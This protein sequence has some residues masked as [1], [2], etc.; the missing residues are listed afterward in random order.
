MDNALLLSRT[1]G[2]RR[3]ALRRDGVLE[4][5]LLEREQERGVVGNVY[6]GR[7]LRVLPGM[8][9]AFVEIG[10]ER[11]AFLYVGD[12][13]TAEQRAK[14]LAED[15]DEDAVSDEGAP[16]DA[17]HGGLTVEAPSPISA[18]ERIQRTIRIQDVVKP[19][20]ELLVQVTK[21]AMRTKG[22]RIT[23]QVTLPGRFLVYMP[24]ADHIGVSRRIADGDERA[25]LRDVVQSVRTPGEGF[26]ARTACEGR[27]AEELTEDITFLRELYA[28]I[29]EKAREQSAPACLHQDLDLHLRAVRDTMADDIQRIVVSSP[30]EHRRVQAFVDRFLP[31]F[32]GR[33]ELWTGEGELFHATGVDK[34][35]GRALS[36]RVSLP[37]GAYLVIDHTEALTAIDVNTGRYV[38]KRS[39]EDTILEVNL[40][41][42]KAVPEQLRLRGIGGLIVVDFIDMTPLDHRAQVDEALADA[43]ASDPA[44]C[45]ALPISDFGL[46]QITRH[47][48][49]DDLGRQLNVPCSSCKG[50]GKRRAP[51]VL[52]Y[53]V[54]RSIGAMVGASAHGD[55]VVRCAPQVI[56][57]IGE[58][59]KGAIPALEQ[60]LGARVRLDG[61]KDM[62]DRWSVSWT[63]GP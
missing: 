26:I 42:A 31:R 55:L 32:A 21:D 3:M 46:A 47:R 1:F 10:L 62:E 12:A 36:R 29:E 39:L 60:Q 38:G 24:G 25:R 49:R 14:L 52:A 22:A 45:S 53:D 27:S 59:E 34:G 50:E 37:S 5:F 2:E 15:E 6:L 54:L 13:V 57:W 28:S 56:S 51:E 20:E 48:V 19:G 18:R 35:L 61:S 58:H 8:Q 4:A 16:S 40:E 9:A 41:A 17:D 23:R 33:V 11:A 43:L 7:V 30:E 63:G 44:R